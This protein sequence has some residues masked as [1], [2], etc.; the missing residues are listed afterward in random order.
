MQNTPGEL[1]EIIA[2]LAPIAHPSLIVGFEN[3]DDAAAVRLDG[4]GGIALLSTG[5]LF[6]PVVD[7]PGDW[8]SI[9]ASAVLGNHSFRKK[10]RGLAGP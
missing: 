2:G 5:D 9:A 6:T 4:D 10:S 8:G 1:E 7:D 3:G